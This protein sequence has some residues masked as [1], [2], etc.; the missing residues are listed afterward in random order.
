M[1]C[2]TVHVGMGIAY[3]HVTAWAWRPGKNQNKVVKMVQNTQ[4]SSNA[5]VL[6]QAARYM[7]IAYAGKAMVIIVRH[8]TQRMYHKA[9]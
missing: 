1:L 7:A 2:N 4:A 8:G 3:I 9:A 6:R 5:K